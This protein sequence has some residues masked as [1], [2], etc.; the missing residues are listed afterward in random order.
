MATPDA[1]TRFGP[2]SRG[3]GRADPG[4]PRRI[5]RSRSGTREPPKLPFKE[6]PLC[7][8]VQSLDAMGFEV[9]TLIQTMA[10][11]PITEGL[12]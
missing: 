2:Q 1:S 6:L 8:A 3:A 7:D 11:P 12:I 5:L 9:A 10:I 4:R